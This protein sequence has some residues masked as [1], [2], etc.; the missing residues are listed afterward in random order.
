MVRSEMT[1]E[2]AERI[3]V[4]TTTIA[5][6]TSGPDTALTQN[7]IST[8][9][10]IGANLE[11]GT[12]SMREQDDLHYGITPAAA[13]EFGPELDLLQELDFLDDENLEH[14]P[15]E[16]EFDASAAQPEGLFLPD[17]SYDLNDEA[18]AEQFWNKALTTQSADRS[19]PGSVN[20]SNYGPSPEKPFTTT[21]DISATQPENDFSPWITKTRYSS[22]MPQT[23]FA[24]EQEQPNS[25]SQYIL[26][27]SADL[28]APKVDGSL[29]LCIPDLP[30]CDLASSLPKDFELPDHPS[31]LNFLKNLQLIG[32]GIQPAMSPDAGSSGLTSP[33]RL[34]KDH[35]GGPTQRR[36]N[37][38][39]VENNAYTPLPQV[40]EK[41]DIFEYTDDGEL[42]PSRLFRQRRSIASYLLILCIKKILI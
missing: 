11:S 9:S 23:Q 5:G 1:D 3:T 7:V 28:L 35:H 10:E 15:F 27:D 36:R 29:D 40:P 20:D 26:V 13:I 8:W 19:S 38:R 4:D 37:R 12:K 18:T 32:E 34:I 41:W 42:D 14:Y 17:F 31:G 25:A 2:M 30:D 24:S 22:L 39:Y 33:R 6:H 21:I 16:P